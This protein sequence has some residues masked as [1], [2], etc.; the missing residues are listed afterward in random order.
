MGAVSKQRRQAGFEAVLAI[1]DNAQQLQDPVLVR[2][3]GSH[4]ERRR[5]PDTDRRH[6]RVARRM[7]DRILGGRAFLSRGATVGLGEDIVVVAIFGALTAFEII[8]APDYTP[9]LELVTPIP[10]DGMT[11]GIGSRTNF[12]RSI[13]ILAVPGYVDGLASVR[14]F[15]APGW[16]E[17]ATLRP[18]E[19]AAFARNLMGLDGLDDSPG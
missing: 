12:A 13:G 16:T 15:V 2:S 9:V 8:D 3:V 1:G 6:Q 10:A 7:P 19:A 11:V 5:Q 17:I 4:L 14:V 18:F